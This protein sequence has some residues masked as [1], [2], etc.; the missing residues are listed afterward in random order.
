MAKNGAESKAST[1]DAAAD[2]E[3]G[4]G[5]EEVMDELETI[6]RQ[7]ESGEL[8]LEDSLDAFE[9]GMNLSKRA[10]SRLNVAEQRVERL[11]S[12]PDGLKTTPFES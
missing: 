9:R 7:L 10:E 2:E 8:S 3:E 11:V 5:F 1:V 4:V 6:V 12:G